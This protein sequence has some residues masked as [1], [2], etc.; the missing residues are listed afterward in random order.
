LGGS[1]H[2]FEIPNPKYIYLSTYPL[3]QIIQNKYYSGLSLIENPSLNVAGMAKSIAFLLNASRFILAGV[4]FIGTGFKTHC[5]G[6]GYENFRIDKI[7]RK[8]PLENFMGSVYSKNISSKNQIAQ[9]TIFSGMNTIHIQDAILTEN[10]TTGTIPDIGMN[11]NKKFLNNLKHDLNLETIKNQ[12][13]STTKIN[14][15]Y[16]N[17]I[18]KYLAP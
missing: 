14:E 8:I 11:I 10:V 2:V 17:R 3:D 18:T 15:R 12:I 5:R 7:N 13:L 4:S 9:K 1:R 16:F 6:T